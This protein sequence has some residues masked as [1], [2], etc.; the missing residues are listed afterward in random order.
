M[1]KKDR[2]RKKLNIAITNLLKMLNY[3][4]TYQF[5]ATLNRMFLIFC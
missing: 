2:E 4:R 1:N 5:V 3:R